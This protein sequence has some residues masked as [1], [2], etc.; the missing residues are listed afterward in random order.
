[1]LCFVLFIGIIVGTMI[2]IVQ[3]INRLP[4]CPNCHHGTFGSQIYCRTDDDYECAK[5]RH[6]Y[7]Y[8]QAMSSKRTDKQTKPLS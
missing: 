2:W 3:T 1:M 4:T 7:K 6:R 8:E 5:C